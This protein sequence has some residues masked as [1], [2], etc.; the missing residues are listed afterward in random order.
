MPYQPLPDGTGVLSVSLPRR[1]IADLLGTTLESISRAA[2][3][4]AD[5]GIIEIRDPARFRILDLPRLI[6]LGKIEG[7]FDKLTV[8]LSRRRSQLESLL[9]PVAEDSVCFCG[10]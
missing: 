2:H 4:L 10:R 6:A 3:K 9:V 8:G 1:D 5:S 7:L